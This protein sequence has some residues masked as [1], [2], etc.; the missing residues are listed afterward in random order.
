MPKQRRVPDD[1][2]PGLGK[3]EA[4]NRL[5]RKKARD[6]VFVVYCSLYI[7]VC[8]YYNNILGGGICAGIFYRQL[9]ESGKL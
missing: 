9:V 3:T 6:S 5:P 4:H 8:F 7:P 2:E 1:N